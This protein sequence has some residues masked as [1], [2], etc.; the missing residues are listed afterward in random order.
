MISAEE[1]S[2]EDA[3]I[4]LPVMVFGTTQLRPNSQVPAAQLLR[5]LSPYEV[6]LSG[7]QVLVGFISALSTV[8]LLLWALLKLWLFEH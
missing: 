7:T 1:I 2:T 4:R 5:N 6:N 8:G 3:Q